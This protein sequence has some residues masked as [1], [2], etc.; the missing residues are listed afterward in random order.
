[1]S[2]GHQK[3]QQ[4]RESENYLGSARMLLGQEGD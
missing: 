1:M 4:I 2:G 3:S